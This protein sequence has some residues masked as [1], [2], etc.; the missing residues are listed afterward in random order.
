[1]EVVDESKGP[2]VGGV[3]F[4]KRYKKR[5]EIRSQWK[6]DK[7]FANF[8]LIQRRKSSLVLDFIISPIFDQNRVVTLPISISYHIQ[9]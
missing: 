3:D 7:S 9:L 4:L 5:Y 2:G 1:M 6:E 8:E